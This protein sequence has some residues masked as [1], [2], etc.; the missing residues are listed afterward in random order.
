MAR[1]Q[2][3]AKM[4][5][6]WLTCIPN[7]FDPGKDIPLGPW[8]FLGKEHLFPDWDSFVFEPDPLDTMEEIAYHSEL[9]TSFANAY[10]HKMVAGLNR[11]NNCNYSAEFWRILTFPWLIHLVHST[12]ERQLRINQ[13]LKKYKSVPI[14]VDLVEN[15]FD[16]DFKDTSNF[17]D[18]GICEP[19]Y[20]EWLFS[21]LLEKR[22]PP[23]WKVNWKETSHIGLK[24]IF[25]K[26]TIQS[27][28]ADFFTTFCLSRT[29]YGIGKLDAILFELLLWI[30]SFRSA[31]PKQ[32]AIDGNGDVLKLEWNL[33]WEDL[34][35]R[36]MPRFFKKIGDNCDHCRLKIRKQRFYLL[37]PVTY[38]N[39][40]AKLHL[41]KSVE[42]GAKLITTQHGSNYGIDKTFA[43]PPEIEYKQY[44]FLSW[45]W[46]EQED[47][48]GNIL[49]LS[50]P[51]L[52]K[53][54]YR[55]NGN[56][57]LILVGR[58]LLLFSL[59]IDWTS[60]ILKTVKSRKS[61]LDFMNGV[62]P[63]ILEHVIFRPFFKIKSGADD[64]EYFKKK[65]PNLTIFEGDRLHDK[66][67]SCKLMVVPAITTIFFIGMAANVPTICFFDEDIE[68]VCRQAKPYIEKLKRAGIIFTSEKEAA[69]KV[70][71]IW[72]DVMGWWEQVEVQ[73]AREEWV[74]RYARKSKNWR[75]EWIK[76]LWKL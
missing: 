7:D 40:K 15:N 67:A 34:I 73:K 66:I 39:E 16:W 6:L 20:N 47:Y 50:A 63:E 24:S 42:Y 3:H 46:K 38:F 28:L 64:R 57:K 17:I 51:L 31:K 4:K 55:G 70:D 75:R 11:M 1:L 72:E 74:W 45:G 9:A 27:K 2:K 54:K 30:K 29:V 10:L 23:Q 43:L 35:Y 32:F 5:R 12:W 71:E 49:P 44:G 37:G 25:E 58:R 52:D 48:K 22:I 65:I 36:T 76:A 68:V 13:F 8:C 53:L 61:V 56:D 21:R 33:N 18:N 14:E 41:A 69:R 60:Q 19:F 62:R 26:R 59:R